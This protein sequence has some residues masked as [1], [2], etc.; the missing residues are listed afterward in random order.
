MS[1]VTYPVLQVDEDGGSYFTD[2]QVE[3]ETA[4]FVPGIPL[5]DVAVPAA[6]SSLT[7]CRCDANYMSDWHPP[8][9][10]Q[11]VVVLE[12]GFDVTSSSGETRR[13]EPGAMILVEDVTGLGHQTRTVGS[14]PCVF[15]AVAIDDAA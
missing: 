15:V 7:L 8:P 11:V 6:V 2:R 4:V 5:V 13:L 10:R 9:R 1:V 14:D 12:G 3:L